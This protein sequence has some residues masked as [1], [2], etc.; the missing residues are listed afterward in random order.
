MIRLPSFSPSP[1]IP[2]CSLPSSHTG[3]PALPLMCQA[4]SC[5][6][7]SALAAGSAWNALT[8]NSHPA[9]SL[10]SPGLCSNAPFQSGQWSSRYKVYI[11]SPLNMD[12]LFILTTFKHLYTF[13]ICYFFI[14]LPYQNITSLRAGKYFFPLM[15]LSTWLKF[16]WTFTP[17][18]F[19][20][21]QGLII[22]Y[23]FSWPFLRVV[24]YLSHTSDIHKRAGEGNMPT[25]AIS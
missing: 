14:F 13:L 25:Q 18:K 16:P 5:L 15:N 24:T 4:H 17:L 2:P 21:R 20:T 9:P 10:T 8:W 23:L 1:P 12:Q 11:A 19:A 6:R 22:A 7:T 3:L